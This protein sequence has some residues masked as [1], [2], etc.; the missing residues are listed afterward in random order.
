MVEGMFCPSL[1]ESSKQ[2]PGFVHNHLVC[3]I[4]A[5][6]GLSAPL[7]K[8]SPGSDLL[9]ESV[10]IMVRTGDHRHALD[11]HYYHKSVYEKSS[12]VTELLSLHTYGRVFH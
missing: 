8:I 5:M 1:L 10:R 11:L 12:I 2:G 3:I 9:R 4:G 7:M 6:E